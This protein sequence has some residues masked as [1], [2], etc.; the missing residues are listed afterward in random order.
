MQNANYFAMIECKM[1]KKKI[2]VMFSF[3]QNAEFIALM[4]LFWLFFWPGQNSKWRITIF[5]PKKFAWCLVPSCKTMKK[6]LNFFGI[7]PQI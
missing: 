2:T 7:G 3:I 1:Q 5:L 6:N 4:R